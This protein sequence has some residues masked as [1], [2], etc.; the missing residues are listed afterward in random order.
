MITSCHTS[1][2]V[3]WRKWGCLQIP[4]FGGVPLLALR[5]ICQAWQLLTWFPKQVPNLLW[6]K[7]KPDLL[8]LHDVAQSRIS[9]LQF[10]IL[11]VREVIFTEHYLRGTHSQRHSKIYCQIK[12]DHICLAIQNL[13]RSSCILMW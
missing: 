7:Q 12:L 11:Q 2:T 3:S 10:L 4:L 9:T 8:D 5:I 1:K 6:V 13:A